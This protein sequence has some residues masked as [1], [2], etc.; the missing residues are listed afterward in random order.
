MP[1]KKVPKVTYNE[2]LPIIPVDDFLL[3]VRKKDRLCYLRFFVSLPEGVREQ[4]KFMIM[5]ND[6]RSMLDELCDNLDH[7]PI[8][9]KKRLIKKNTKEELKQL[10]N[11]SEL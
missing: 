11:K 4:A 6:L 5:E 3:S 7:F 1:Q 8:P 9:K 10:L 2:S